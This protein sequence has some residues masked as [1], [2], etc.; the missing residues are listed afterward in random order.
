MSPQQRWG[1]LRVRPAPAKRPTT[2]QLRAPL[3]PFADRWYIFG[4]RRLAAGRWVAYAALRDPDRE[5]AHVAVGANGPE[6]VARLLELLTKEDGSG[7]RG[8]RRREP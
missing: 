2:P 5:L 4:P 1:T 6:A 3:D 7:D 8:G